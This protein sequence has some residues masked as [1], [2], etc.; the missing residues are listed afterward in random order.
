MATT[1]NL[2]DT[3]LSNPTLQSRYTQQ[4]YLDLFGGGS[5]PAP[6]PPPP[7][8]PAPTPPGGVTNII[9]QNLRNDRPGTA[10]VDATDYTTFD[11][12]NYG[13]GGKLEIN[14]AALQIGFNADG[15]A[16]GIASF[17]QTAEQAAFQK[18]LDAGGPFY[19][20]TQQ[21]A[22]QA[23]TVPTKMGP[24]PQ[25]YY[26]GQK[27]YKTPRTIG[28]QVY[29]SQL[30]Q[31]DTAQ[32]REF[33]EANIEGLPGNLTRQELVDMYN[34]YSKFFGRGS[35]FAA[36]RIPGQVSQFMP[37]QKGLQAIFG[38]PGDK[39]MQTRYGVEGGFGGGNT[40]FRDEFGLSVVDD[41]KR[42][43]GKKDRDYL[44]RMTER[45][46][47]LTDFFSGERKSFTGKK[48]KG[49]FASVEN[50]KE[51]IG[52]YNDMSPEEK[53]AL[54]NEMAK[55]NGFM[56]KQFF[57]YKFNRIPVETFNQQ[58]IEKEK[59]EKQRKEDEKAGAFK[60]TVQLDP[61]SDR[62]GGGGTWHQQTAAKERQ[63]QKVA[64]PG[65]GQGAYFEDGGRVYLYDRKEMDNGGSTNDSE[66]EALRKKV[67]ELMDDG[68]EFGE[69]VREA[70]RQGYDNGGYLGEG[71]FPRLLLRPGENTGRKKPGLS[72]YDK[73]TQD[74]DYYDDDIIEIP[75]GKMM[76]KKTKKKKKDRE[77]Y[78]DGGRVYLY[79]RQD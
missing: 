8:T 42:I 76:K 6:S 54:Y 79:D 18:R 21:L 24:M 57:A 5:T 11:K 31:G 59:K 3:Y 50:F 25:G 9:G 28:E 71:D 49:T 34:D 4:Q 43:F 29:A 72:D 55:I 67:E 51:R 47:E 41:N 38:P 70:M 35:N 13:P 45:V 37:L 23:G 60:K 44:D 2:I 68:Y 56:T 32:L 12:R 14:P 10:I 7:T 77:D 30:S 48:K 52:R 40:K 78:S 46:D 39:S 36:A 1:Q 33:M 19:G 26:T 65:F 16:K 73:D 61:G 64:G 22:I 15:T 20:P 17:P 62:G 69:A 66:A 63:K 74:Y 58:Q 27:E 53:A 75:M